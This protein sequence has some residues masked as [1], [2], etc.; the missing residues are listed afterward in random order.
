[1]VQT[2]SIFR[3]QKIAIQK[4]SVVNTDPKGRHV[5]NQVLSNTA[6]VFLPSL[7]AMAGLVE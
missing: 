1:M 2:I 4:L 5:I 6:I 3:M 7:D